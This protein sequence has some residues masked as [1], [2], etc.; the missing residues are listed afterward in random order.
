MY[1][2]RM[3]ECMNVFYQKENKHIKDKKTFSGER[4]FFF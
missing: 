4:V 1:E 2:C 3:S